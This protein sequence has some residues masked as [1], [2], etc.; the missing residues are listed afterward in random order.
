M[1]PVYHGSELL[2]EVLGDHRADGFPDVA[3]ILQG[4]LCSTREPH[5][6]NLDD[7]NVAMLQDRYFSYWKYAG[8]YYEI[9]DDIWSLFVTAK[10]DNAAIVADIEQALLASGEFVKEAVDFGRFK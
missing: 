9:D 10:V 8:G 3:A 7:P 6:E 2:V 1:R 5:P 4:A